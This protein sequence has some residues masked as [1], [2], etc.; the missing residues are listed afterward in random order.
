MSNAHYWEGKDERAK[1]ALKHTK[2]MENAYGEEIRNRIDRSV[3]Y[4]SCELVAAVGEPTFV[5]TP[6]D[7][8][9]EI[10]AQ[11]YKRAVVLNFASYKNAGGGFTKGSC[12][13]E[14]SL[15]MESYLFNVLRSFQLK[16]Y[17][18][19]GERLKRGLYTDA[20]IYTPEV[21]F[22]KGDAVKYC[23]VLTCAAPNNSLR[24]KYHSFTE[25]E[26]T[27]ALKQRIEF[28]RN[29]IESSGVDV[30]ILGAWGCGVFQ[31]DAREVATLFKEAFSQTNL[32]RVVFAVPCSEH[33]KENYEAFADVFSK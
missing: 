10:F 9:S 29:I 11:D 24:F 14:E 19:N 22:L 2:E 30:A 1:M 5:V 18:F 32:S 26:N 7:S 17:E 27:A 23:D 13:Q 3:I 21:L 6:N 20:A 25:E 8:V 31:Q 16:F 12:A 28:V 33:S 15:C 4:R